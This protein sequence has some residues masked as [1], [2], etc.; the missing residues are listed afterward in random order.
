M[1]KKKYYIHSVICVLI[2]FGFQFI[3]PFISGISETGMQVLGIFLG[4]LYG[5]TFVE[6]IWPS[7]LGMIACGFTGLMTVQDSLMQGF[8]S[9]L[10]MVTLFVFIFTAFMEASG[11]N[12]WIAN[13]FISRKL[14]IGR[15]YIFL[16]M[17]CLSAWILAM[18][19]YCFAAIIVIWS[20]FYS[21]SKE[22]K[23]EKRSPFV[24]CV[25]FG[26]A[27]AGTL[28]GGTLPFNA[29]SIIVLGLM[30]SS[31]NISVNYV[32]FSLINLVFVFLIIL[33]YVLVCKYVFKPDPGILKDK[34]D[35][36]AHL[37]HVQMNTDQKI[38]AIAL[39]VFLCMLLLPGVLPTSWPVVSQLSTLNVSGSAVLILCILMLLRKS[40]PV[41]PS[42][43]IL[44][45][46][47]CAVRGINWEVVILLASTA[48]ISAALESDESGVLA[49]CEAFLRA[50]IGDMSP[51]LAIA[52]IVV[53][54]GLLT[55]VMH[56][57][58]LLIIFIPMLCP[59]LVSYDINPVVMAMPLLIVVQAAF[60]TPAAS[61]QAAMVFSNAE[62]IDKKWAFMLG[63]GS[64][65]IT[66]IVSLGG[67][68]P[69]ANLVF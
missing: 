22:L 17:I 66:L 33:L 11:L 24:N 40:T 27:F 68:M 47:D 64:L 32:L 38:A 50:Q 26:I 63:T 36:F 31:V 6:M 60:M 52:F 2:M 10:V 21:I 46:T 48:P 43:G 3:P 14:V 44:Y 30:K 28:G 12:Q 35:R 13:W 34:I 45:W 15:P 59:L 54:L 69:A 53:A 51:F 42:K 18:F 62:W 7:L 4:M 67:I 41:K 16:L 19:T 20:V 1:E 25:I 39:V 9:D 57:A 55:Q 5:W 8:G 29:L 65:I 49:S 58:V 61:T 56:N 23:L 37:R